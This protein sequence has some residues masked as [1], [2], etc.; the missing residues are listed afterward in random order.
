MPLINV[1]MASGRTPEQ[2]RALMAAITQAAVDT[3]D[4]PLASVRVWIDEFE[5]E[6]F[7]AGGETLAERQRRT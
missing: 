5:P 4:A 7:M 1:H 3:L 2:K 6:E